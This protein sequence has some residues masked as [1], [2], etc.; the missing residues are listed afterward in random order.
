MSEGAREQ[1]FGFGVWRGGRRG[2][3]IDGGRLFGLGARDSGGL[4]QSITN[5]QES[6]ILKNH[7]TQE[8]VSVHLSGWLSVYPANSSYTNQHGKNQFIHPPSQLHRDILRY[9]ECP[10]VVVE[11]WS[12]RA[13]G[14]GDDARTV[15]VRGKKE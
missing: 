14:D 12:V 13:G 11:V 9:E 15:R 1:G 2:G 7:N 8:S 4:E 5:T 6:Q 10:A 3:R